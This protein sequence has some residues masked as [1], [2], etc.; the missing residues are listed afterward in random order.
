[1]RHRCVIKVFEEIPAPPGERYAAC[2][3]QLDTKLDTFGERES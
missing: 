2:F 3:C 1:M